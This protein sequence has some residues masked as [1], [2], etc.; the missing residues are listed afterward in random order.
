MPVNWPNLITAIDGGISRLQQVGALLSE[1][2]DRTG[3][4][5]GQRQKRA[6]SGEHEPRSRPLKREMGAT[7][8]SGEAMMPLSRCVQLRGMLECRSY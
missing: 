8:E 4:R 6:L 5:G 1:N 2:T 3:T 7:E